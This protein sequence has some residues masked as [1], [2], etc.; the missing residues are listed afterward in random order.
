MISACNSSAR[1]FSVSSAE[2]VDPTTALVTA[3]SGGKT[4]TT[5]DEFELWPP[6]DRML[7][8]AAQ[9]DAVDSFSKVQAA[10]AQ[11]SISPAAINPAML[12]S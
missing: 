2:A 8:Q 12:P 5:P 7:S 3:R 11:P 9:R 4:T 10:Q 6:T 1:R